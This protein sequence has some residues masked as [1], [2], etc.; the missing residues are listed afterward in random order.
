[1]TSNTS[2][3]IHQTMMSSATDP[4]IG[5]EQVG[6]LGAPRCD[7]AQVIGEL[8]L[9]GVEGVGALQADRPQV[10]HVEGHRRTPARPVLG[11]RACGVGERHQPAPETHQLGPEGAVT[12][13]QGRVPQ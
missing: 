2:S 3:A 1:M 4:S 8:A 5:I 11:Q 9:Q 10:A 6:V 12:L 7:L 13:F